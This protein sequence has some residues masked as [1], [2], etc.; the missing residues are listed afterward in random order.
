MA[1]GGIGIETRG[2][3]TFLAKVAKMPGAVQNAAFKAMG[4]VG[5]ELEK[6]VKVNHLSGQDLDVRTGN[7]RRAIFHEVGRTIDGDAFAKVGA[8]I[9][10]AP[11]A[12][13]HELGG[14]IRPKKS[15]HLTIP[16]TAAQTRKGVARFSARDVIGNPSGFGYVGTFTHNK[17][18]FGKKSDG[19]IEPL[20][21]LA[22]QVTVK[23]VGY[24]T[25]S[26]AEKRAWI[27]STVRQ[28]VSDAFRKSLE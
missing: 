25:K 26:A 21:K 8:D 20:F 2:I 5:R 24:L 9:K 6:H 17:I 18:I 11:Y 12:R 14:I 19:S 15:R 27:E 4:V 10:K 7:L 28:Y 22:D 3:S 16:L 23:A 13:V 1:F